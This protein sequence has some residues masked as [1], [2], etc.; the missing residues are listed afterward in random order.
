MAMHR[1]KGYFSKTQ[2]TPA[3]DVYSLAATLYTLVTAQVPI[4]AT[5]RENF[6]L[7]SPQNIQP[8]LSDRVSEVIMLGMT[9]EPED[10]PNS[11]EEW[12]AFLPP[13]SKHSKL[14]TA[15]RSKSK[16]QRSPVSHHLSS[17]DK[18]QSVNLDQIESVKVIEKNSV[19]QSANNNQFFKWVT[20]AL[21]ILLGMDYIWLKIHFRLRHI[22]T[23]PNITNQE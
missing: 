8:K 7:P 9:L 14:F 23:E 4:A 11:V 17:V 16:R 15:F 20:I 3:T 21:L 5:L 2:P 19:K 18:T 22:P 6:T 10:R 12:L 13:E 1:S